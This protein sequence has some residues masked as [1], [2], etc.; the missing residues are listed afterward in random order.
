MS[1]SSETRNPPSSSVADDIVLNDATSVTRPSTADKVGTNNSK[2]VKK[3]GLFSSSKH[4]SA[5]LAGSSNMA[6]GQGQ[7]QG[8]VFSR[9]RSERFDKKKSLEP[10]SKTGSSSVKT[11]RKTSNKV[12][13]S[14]VTHE[15]DATSSKYSSTVNYIPAGVITPSFNTANVASRRSS[16]EHNVDVEHTVHP[17]SPLRLASETA[18]SQSGSSFSLAT[19]TGNNVTRPSTMEVVR[20]R[21]RSRDDDEDG[22]VSSS[23]LSSASAVATP[24][25]TVVHY[26]LS[27][28]NCDG[29]SIHVHGQT[30][31][32]FATGPLT[33]ADGDVKRL[34]WVDGPTLATVSPTGTVV[35]GTP[36]IPRLSSL[37]QEEA[38]NQS[39]EGG[40]F[41]SNSRY[42]ANSSNFSNNANPVLLPQAPKANRLN[43]RAE[44][45]GRQITIDGAARGGVGDEDEGQGLPSSLH[46]SVTSTSSVL[47]LPSAVSAPL[48][49]VSASSP[50][51]FLSSTVAPDSRHNN[52][53]NNNNS[54]NS[55]NNQR[56]SSTSP[57]GGGKP[58]A[59]IQPRTQQ[60]QQQQQQQAITATPVAMSAPATARQQQRQSQ[61]IQPVTQLSP[62]RRPFPQPP[63]QNVP[64]QPSTAG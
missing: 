59:V 57:A 62:N 21:S 13:P 64:T 50:D 16:T 52:N 4:S 10:S 23:K 44:A 5:S 7:G 3:F 46:P 14:P 53:N 40:A 58:V 43:N 9:S 41:N 30:G 2:P 45:S 60:Q 11:R 55:N 1:S 37:Q 31:R 48:A 29:L 8:E 34:S 20:S 15:S 22:G 32:V 18:P 47:S 24:P 12:P 39:I 26:H 6:E 28:K 25:P 19:S 27:I 51:V 61:P 42:V 54:N 49:I 35:R 17:R 63:I 33:V 36:Y 56:R 38:V